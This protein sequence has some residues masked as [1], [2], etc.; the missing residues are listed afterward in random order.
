FGF[1]Q[2]LEPMFDGIMRLAFCLDGYQRQVGVEVREGAKGL[3]HGVVHGLTGDEDLDAVRRQTA[4][5]LSLDPDGREFA[6]VGDRD[7]VIG[8]LQAAAPGL[9]P[10]LFYSAYEAAVWS[11]M[12]ARRPARQMAE[13]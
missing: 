12:S 1:G 11:V 5:V 10:P 2:R 8:K 3:V 7:P 6:K 4:R 13:V 9:R